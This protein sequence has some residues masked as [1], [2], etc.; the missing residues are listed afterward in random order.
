MEMISRKK[1]T[2]LKNWH[3]LNKNSFF[4]A[5]CYFIVKHNFFHLQ[6]HKIAW[7]FHW[8]RSFAKNQ[9]KTYQLSI[10]NIIKK[11]EKND[12]EEIFLKNKKN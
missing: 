2:Y 5:N 6:Y 4:N 1:L 11:Y 12:V 7:K 10:N 9:S 8:N 3:L